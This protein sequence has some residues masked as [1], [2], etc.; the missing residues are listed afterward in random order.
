MF[1]GKNNIYQVQN[2]PRKK[3]QFH[4]RHLKSVYI[5][6]KWRRTSTGSPDKKP[7]VCKEYKNADW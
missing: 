1:Y 2:T 5:M 7:T 3:L 4:T 6:E